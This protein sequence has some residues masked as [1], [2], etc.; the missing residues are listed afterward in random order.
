VVKLVIILIAFVQLATLFGQNYKTIL[1]TLGVGGVALAL[2]GKNSVENFFGTLMVVSTRPFVIGDSIIVANT[3]GKVERIGMRS[4]T[5][6]TYYGYE[7]IVPNAKFIAN[8]IDNKG[9]RV[10]RHA[11]FT[12][13]VTYDTPIKTLKAFIS[14]IKQLINNRASMADNSTSVSF[15]DFNDSSLDILVSVYISTQKRSVEVTER[16]AFLL[17]ILQL[18]NELKVNFAFP[19]RTIFTNKD[20]PETFISFQSE[21]EAKLYGVEVADKIKNKNQE[22]C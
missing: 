21:D 1:A 3:A 5:L 7:I 11:K 16:E 6:K 15:N 20:E 9:R 10:L 19:T 8:H 22:T 14:G 17:D 12:L 4:T 13:G 18:A 2:A